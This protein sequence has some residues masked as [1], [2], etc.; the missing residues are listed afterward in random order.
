MQTNPLPNLYTALVD[1][2]PK[3]VPPP[4]PELV[5]Y[6]GL[7]DFDKR[8]EPKFWD[9]EFL[10]K[11]LEVKYEIEGYNRDQFLWLWDLF[12][13]EKDEVRKAVIRRKLIE[14]KTAIQNTDHPLKSLRIDFSKYWHHLV[15]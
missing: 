15:S 2:T 10:Q 14:F 11:Y 3:L 1:S 4:P 9:Q 7:S 8:K 13:I 5:E 6:R 12:Q